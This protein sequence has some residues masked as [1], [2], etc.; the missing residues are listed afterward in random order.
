MIIS[1]KKFL[2]KAALLALQ[3]W[4]RFYL[5]V[6]MKHGE[7][8]LAEKEA[9]WYRAWLPRCQVKLAKRLWKR[10]HEIEGISQS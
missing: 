8:T 5:K 7:C 10:G 2:A 9:I 1:H 6:Q 4:P 3:G